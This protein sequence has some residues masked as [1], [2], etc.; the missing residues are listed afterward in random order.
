MLSIRVQ[1]AA[2]HLAP[3]VNTD[4]CRDDE[5]LRQQLEE[6]YVYRCQAGPQRGRSSL[7]KEYCESEVGEKPATGK[8]FRFVRACV[9]A[10]SIP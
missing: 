2:M 10:V 5:D 7:S 3:Y 9:R 8:S 4:L 1:A 6:Q